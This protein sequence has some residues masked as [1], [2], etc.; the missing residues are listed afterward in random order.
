MSF[1]DQFPR[2]Y[3]TSQT[4]PVP[5][6]LNARH[7]AIV[8]RNA[9]WLAGARVLDI[10]SHDGRWTFAALKAGA[11]HVIGIEPRQELIDSARETFSEYGIADGTHELWNSG[12]MEAID[13]VRVDTVLCLGF[14]YHTR[15]H[16]DLLDRIERTGARLVVI[17]TEI[18][19]EK[20]HL[21]SANG[22]PRQVFGNP[23]SFDLIRDEVGDQQMAFSDSATRNGYTLVMRPSRA[24]IHAM[25]AHF[26][27]RVSEFDWAGHFVA[28]PAHVASMVDYSEG[29][30]STFYLER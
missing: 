19:P 27:F 21:S 30:R 15:Y 29:W 13:G 18:V 22:E 2:F 10:A 9:S 1:F 28:N 12:V 16:I 20:L 26:G 6:R 5:D 24:A 11:S 3:Q 7:L 4:S 25:A 23:F 17:D 14:Y 8:K